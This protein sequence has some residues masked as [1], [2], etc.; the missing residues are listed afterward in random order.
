MREGGWVKKGG[1]REGASEGWGR[2]EGG[3]RD[4]DREGGKEDGNP[5]EAG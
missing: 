3:R 5:S 2:R 4:V 1:E